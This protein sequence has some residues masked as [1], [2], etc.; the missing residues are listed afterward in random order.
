MTHVPRKAGTSPRSTRPYFYSERNVKLVG[1]P[2]KTG[3]VKE[4]GGHPIGRR[5]LGTGEGFRM[6]QNTAVA[7]LCA[8]WRGTLFGL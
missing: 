1:Q 6:R 4:P 8:A 7:Y 2:E 5:T 3:H